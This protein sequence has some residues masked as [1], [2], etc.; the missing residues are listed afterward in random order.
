M[1]WSWLL[2]FVCAIGVDFAYSKWIGYVAERR[3]APAALWSS[4]TTISGFLA[5][6][7]CVEEH[8]A[9]IPAALGNALGTLIAVKKKRDASA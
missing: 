3:R 2:A 1:L 7:I 4:L 9:V 5:L 6:L 8:S